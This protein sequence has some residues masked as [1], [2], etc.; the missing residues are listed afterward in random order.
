MSVFE[1]DDAGFLSHVTKTGDTP[2]VNLAQANGITIAKVGDTFYLF[3]AG[4]LDDGISVFAI[5][6][7]K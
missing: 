3:V 6:D 2:E 5:K 4:S 1:I 7:D